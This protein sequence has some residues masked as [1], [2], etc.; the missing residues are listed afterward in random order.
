MPIFCGEFQGFFTYQPLTELDDGTILKPDFKSFPDQKIEIW[1]KND[2][3]SG[4]QNF[5]TQSIV[6][7]FRQTSRG[8]HEEHRRPA[9]DEGQVANGLEGE[10]KNNNGEVDQNRWL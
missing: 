4:V 6:P 5:P 1:E 7:R 3:Q 2:A 9:G 8:G 10:R